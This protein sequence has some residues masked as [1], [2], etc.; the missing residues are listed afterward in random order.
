MTGGTALSGS[1]KFTYDGVDTVLDGTGGGG[2]FVTKTPSQY[3]AVN[4]YGLG[5]ETFSSNLDSGLIATFS[6]SFATSDNVPIIQMVDKSTG[7]TGTNAGNFRFNK[8]TGNFIL[9][10][11]G[12]GKDTFLLLTGSLS[13]S[14]SIFLPGV[15]ENTNNLSTLMIDTTTGKVGYTGSYGGGGGGAV[16]AIQGNVN[17]NILTATG[18]TNI[19]GSAKFTYDGAGDVHLEGK[20]QIDQQTITI[21]GGNVSW[22]VNNGSNATVTLGSGTNTLVMSNWE[23]G[24]TG[25]LVVKQ[26]GTGGRTLNIDL[27]G[28]TVYLGNTS[29]TPSTAANA[30]DVLGW[31]YDGSKYFVTIGYGDSSTVGAKGAPGAQ[32]ATGPTGNTGPQGA[33]GGIGPIGNTGPQG[34]TGPDGVIGPTGNIGPIGNIGPVGNTGPQGA[35]GDDGGVGPIGNIGPIGNTGPQGADGPDGNVGPIGNIGPI[36]N[37]GPQGA[38]GGIGPIGNSG[39]QGVA[40]GI[41]PIGNTG[42]QGATGTQGAVGGTGT[43]FT[44][45]GTTTDGIVTFDSTNALT[46]EANM[47]FDGTTAYINGALGVGTTNPTTVGLIEATNDI[48]AYYSSDERLKENIKPIPWALDKIQKINGVTFDWKPLTEEQKIYIHGHEGSDIGVIAQEIEKVL[49]EV[50]TTRDNGFKA[51]KYEKIVALLIEAIKEQQSEI[52]QL[53]DKI[54]G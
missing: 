9:T 35:T 11:S 27:S 1:A 14:Q 36:G 15:E 20:L 41:G 25:V 40:G 7:G 2:Y 16:T 17:D 8:D 43:E 12:S 37:T 13:V 38:D 39:P 51:V 26:D 44:V 23:T 42:P 30:I 50:V 48:V 5:H 3:N 24:D 29:Y 10:P 28:N 53:K 46:T 33:D 6:S 18:G 49:P 19:S 45:T 52:D 34:A 31:Y 4:E 21:A 54:N 22:N 32:G 47:T